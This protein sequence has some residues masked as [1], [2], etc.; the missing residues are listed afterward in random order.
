M[1]SIDKISCKGLGKRY[2]REWIFRGIQL[3]F[4]KGSASAVLG[5]NGSGKS[6]FIQI[7]SGYM[8]QSEGSILYEIDGKHIEQEKVYKQ[9]SYSAPYLELIEDFSFEEA[10]QFQSRFKGFVD[11]MSEAEVIERSGL[12][13]D[14]GKLIKYF[15]SGM[16]Q[17]VKLILSILADTSI[18]FLDEPASNLDKSGIDWYRSLID[19]YRRDRFVFVCSNQQEHEFDFCESVIRIEDYKKK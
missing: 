1:K 7:L 5:H 8:M 9:I 14:A 16:K 19:E 13:K 10:V 12:K 11:K 2:N 3:E 4:L 6:T 18:L 15:S 17:R